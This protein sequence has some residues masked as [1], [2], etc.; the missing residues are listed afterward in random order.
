[1]TKTML[2][3]LLPAL[4]VASALAGCAGNGDAGATI[5]QAGSSTVY[6]IA[7]AWAAELAKQGIQVVVSGGGSGR[8]ASALCAGEIAIGD[9]SRA[10][11]DSE[12]ADCRKNGIEPVTWKVAF[13]GITIVASKENDFIDHLTVDELQHIWRA[14]DPARTWR[15][16]RPEWPAEEIKLFGPDSDSGTYE[17][18][19]EEILGKKCGADSKSQCPIRSDFQPAA[20]DNRVVEGVSSTKHALGHFGFAYY[21]E[22]K[23]RLRAIPIAEEDGEPVT[24]DFDTIRN[25]AY[26]PLSRPVFMVTNGKPA[27]G[28]PVHTYFTYAMGDGQNVVSEV[29]YVPLDDATIAEQRAW[30]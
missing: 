6:P 10:L 14:D 12:V 11:K 2:S 15:D 28:T 5:Q 8:G 18:F 22:N 25:G 29:G 30:L 9:M 19:N 1:M 21:L 7:E 4:L 20:D 17:Y 24:P 13:D 27:P 23:D 3:L 26:K 16:V